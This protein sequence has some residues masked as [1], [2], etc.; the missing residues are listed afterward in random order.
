MKNKKIPK[1]DLSGGNDL[2]QN[3]F[4]ELQPSSPASQIPQPLES[5]D[6]PQVNSKGRRLEI[7]RCKSGN[8]KWMVR[9]VGLVHSGEVEQYAKELKKN[10]ATGGTIKNREIEIQGDH[11]D[12]VM[13]F[14]QSRGYR[15]VQ[16]GG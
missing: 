6:I 2:Q 8:G 10:L 12:K 13:D 5:Q 7:H 14:F 4:G 9:V 1:K 11:R 15:P 3:V 16:V